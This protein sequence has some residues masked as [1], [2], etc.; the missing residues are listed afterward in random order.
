MTRAEQL[1][2]Q[3][4]DF[5]KAAVIYYQDREGQFPVGTLAALPD[6]NHDQK[7][8]ELSRDPVNYDHCFIRDFVSAGIAFIS[9]G[10]R[11]LVRNFLEF[12]L[13]LQI[14][15]DEQPPIEENLPLFMAAR[16][17]IKGDQVNLAQGLMPASFK[18]A[19]DSAITVNVERDFGQRAIGRVLPFDSALWWIFVLNVYENAC[20]QA[21][22]PEEKIAHH[23]AFQRGIYLILKLCLANGFST[24]PLMLV[25]EA[26][27]MIDRRLSVHGYPLEIQVLFYMALSAASNLLSQEYLDQ[28]GDDN[29]LNQIKTR[30][31]ELASYIRD[32]YWLDQNKLTQIYDYQTEQ[33]GNTVL[34]QFNI[35]TNAVPDWVS[36]W[37]M[38]SGQSDTGYLVGNVSVG[39]MDFR[40][41]S[42]G[43][44]L[45]IVSGLITQ[46][47]S[48]G[49]LNLIG[50]QK[51]KLIGHNP[52]KLCYPALEDRDWETLTG[53]DPKNVPWS[54]HNGG[55][56]PVLLWILTAAAVKFNQTQ[57]AQHAISLAEQS[58]D[59]DKWPEY[60]EG[61]RAQRLGRRARLYQTWT[62]SGY[63]VAKELMEKPN[64]LSLLSIIR[65]SC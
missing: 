63:L 9:Q 37:L 56:W 6:S 22:Q 58:L 49:I 36:R 32:H 25:P 31:K 28:V 29:L 15:Y 35:Y 48:E 16:H 42:Q 50:Y 24:T 10:E 40:F 20:E 5:L 52:L 65:R 30:R 13:G 41:F 55:S 62:I 4:W 38:T 47:Q 19:S 51:L 7:K 46:E 61:R 12:T 2:Q 53:C 54:Y 1:R 34:N 45:A 57:L 26:T 11:R 8:D 60:Y 21:G 64:Q 59:V 44:L 18:L 17:L 27:F 43:N 3:A 14:D 23:Q 39:W 33:F